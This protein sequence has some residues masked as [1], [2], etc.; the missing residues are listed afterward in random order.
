MLSPMLEHTD[1]EVATASCI[2][3]LII[4]MNGAA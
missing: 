2:I 1:M 4:L 3:V